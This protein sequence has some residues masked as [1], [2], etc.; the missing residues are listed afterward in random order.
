VR[1]PGHAPAPARKDG[2][3]IVLEPDALLTLEASGLRACT[4]SI[5]P[6]D[7]YAFSE[8]HES[9]SVSRDEL[10]RA[11]A[12]RWM[13]DD[14]WAICVSSDLIDEATSDRDITISVRWR[15]T[16]W[17]LAT[18]VPT[19]G[20]RET[21]TVPCTQSGASSPLDVTVTAAVGE[22]V[23]ALS[24]HLGVVRTDVEHG[25]SEQQRWGVVHFQVPGNFWTDRKLP[26]DASV[27]H[28]DFV[29]TGVS[30][31]LAVRDDASSAYGRIAFVHDG[32]AR[33]LE[34]RPAFELD[35]TILSGADASP[36]AMADLGWQF[37]DGPDQVWGWHSWQRHA[38]LDRD[39]SFRLRGPDAPLSAA[40]SQLDPPNALEL[41]I[42]APGFERYEHRFETAGAQ[43]FDCGEIRLKPLA[44]Q[45]VL[46]PGHG[47]TAKSIEW[48]SL[49]TSPVYVVW[50]IRNGVLESDGS[51]SVH[52]LE[53]DASVPEH[54]A[55]VAAT[56]PDWAPLATPW[57]D[58]APHWITIYAIA[59]DLEGDRLF[60]RRSDGK[61]AA[62]PRRNVDLVL[63]CGAAPP[64]GKHWWIGWKWRDQWGA[65]G[66]PPPNVVGKVVRVHVSAPDPG[67]SLIWSTESTPP[68]ASTASGELG[69]SLP[70]DAISGTV[71]LR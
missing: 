2:E 36:L 12:W 22:R 66:G 11:I 56:A 3:E 1:A 43:R 15:D 38:P 40:G 60:E 45:I 6:Y 54:R 29:P 16:R 4:A 65:L 33:T 61:Y 7:A 28:F 9:E 69:G 58:D 21:W 37:M 14:R 24:V 57:P 67:A 30:L 41:F 68:A 39:G 64:A 50:S 19:P 25:H 27:V 26:A 10:R 34:L 13:S 20:A 35:G 47:L 63:E 71:V 70:F 5:R 23:G 31:C 51:L 53:D 52:L 59:D 42:D 48:S 62:V 49:H 18:F 46:A 32:S 17:A 8:A 44:T 55:F